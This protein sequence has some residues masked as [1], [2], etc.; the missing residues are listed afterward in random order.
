MERMARRPPRGVVV[1]SE[2]YLKNNTILTMV[3][4]SRTRKPWCTLCIALSLFLREFLFAL[5]LLRENGGYM[6]RVSRVR[7]GIKGGVG[8]RDE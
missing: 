3:H 8:W 1:V 7:V 6:R 4:A 2:R 5:P